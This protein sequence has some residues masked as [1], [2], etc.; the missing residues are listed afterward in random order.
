MGGPQLSYMREVRQRELQQLVDSNGHAS[1][2]RGKNF[3]DEF[4]EA[5]TYFHSLDLEIH[6]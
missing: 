1:S 4:D 5:C 6:S 3:H 2:G